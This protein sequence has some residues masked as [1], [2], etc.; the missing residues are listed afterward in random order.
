MFLGSGR[1]HGPPEPD[2]PSPGPDPPGPD[3]PGPDPPGPDP[4]GRA[5]YG[6]FELVWRPHPSLGRKGLAKRAWSK[7]CMRYALNELSY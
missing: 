1:G 7:C 2:S 4:P 3:P 5:R 6:G